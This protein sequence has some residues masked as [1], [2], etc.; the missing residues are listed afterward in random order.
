[1]PHTQWNLLRQIF[2]EGHWCFPQQ[3]SLFLWSGGLEAHRE[4]RDA[5]GIEKVPE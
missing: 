4:E 5:A 3:A 1:M 2:V